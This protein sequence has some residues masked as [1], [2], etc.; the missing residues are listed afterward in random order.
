MQPTDLYTTLA[1]AQKAVR[2]YD[3]NVALAFE[4][5][6]TAR[7]TSG[8]TYRLTAKG[9]GIGAAETVGYGPSAE[10]A[11]RMLTTATRTAW[12]AHRDVAQARAVARSQRA[13]A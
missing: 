6:N 13:A 3:V 11:I 9:N 5:A 12:Q 1:D 10:S 4:L 7:G 2:R 8:P